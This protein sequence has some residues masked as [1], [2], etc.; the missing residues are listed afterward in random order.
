MTDSRQLLAEY[1]RNGAEASFHEL[2][3]RYVNAVYSAALRLV[4]GD[5]HRA[6]DVTQT[7]F[8]D[9][10][11]MA[12]SVSSEAMVGG[13]LHRHTCFVAANLMRGERRRQA[14]ERQAAHMNAS[15]E[16]PEVDWT[17]IAPILDEAINEL[18]KT[19]RMAVL[20]RFFEQRDFHSVGE[21]LGSNEDA[22]RMR[23]NRALEKLR[24]GLKRRGVTTT[25]AALATVLTVGVVETAPAGLAV[26][27]SA[28]AATAGTA[29]GISTIIAA[30]KTIAMTTLQKT[31]IGLAFTAAIGTGIYQAHQ[32]AKLRG[33]I[34]TLQQQCDDD[35]K[36]LA[37]L[38]AKP[39]PA[40]HLPAPQVQFAARPTPPQAYN[41]QTNLYAWLQGNPRLTR[42]QV[43][44]YLGK[45]GRTAANLLAGFRTSGDPALLQEAM[46]KYPND[47]QVDFEAIFFGNL[48]PQDQRQWLN[49]FENSDPNNALPYYLSALNYFNAGQIDQG[50]QELAASSNKSFQDYTTD[51]MEDDEEAF[52]GAGYSPMNADA[53]SLY[54][55]WLPQLG[56]FKELGSDL[57]QL[58]QTYSKAGDQASAQSAFE[59]AANLGQYYADSYPGETIISQLV[60][61]IIEQKALQ[62]MDPNAP[63]GN[64]GQTVQDVL[65]QMAQER[66]TLQQLGHQT[67]TLMPLLSNPDNVT[68][69]NRFIMF[70]EENAAQ[71][72]VNKYGQPSGPQ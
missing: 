43:E 16:T 64:D 41:V 5:A 72:M 50:V 34:Q 44:S 70:G 15:E 55:L 17:L 57:V 9:L 59:A 58:G 60:G 71:W 32:V 36:R 24:I 63:Y 31:I 10:A 66:T 47:P 42:E 33:Q 28:T 20:L 8:V 30:T 35:E 1:A 19:D 7:V 37:S 49:T 68:Y 48:S 27:I 67:D 14:R 26:T 61:T 39:K 4:D 18:G 46:Q 6:Q 52:L 13:W 51:R 54:S 11:R 40:L 2:V 29:A 65:N 12:G 3:T 23:V 25:A 62:A 22:T 69:Y 45:N 21:I 56:Q 38:A 53:L